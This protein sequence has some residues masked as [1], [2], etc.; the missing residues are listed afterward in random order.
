MCETK[1]EAKQKALEIIQ[2]CE[3]LD[4]INV[5]RNYLELF[6]AQFSDTE[7]YNN[8]ISLCDNKEQNLNGDGK[9]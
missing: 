1:E 9:L 3:N 6:L 4:Q 2:S 5:C 8:L 7:E